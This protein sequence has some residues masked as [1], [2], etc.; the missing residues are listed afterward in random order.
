M[1][2]LSKSEMID[3]SMNSIRWAT[4]LNSD[5][6]SKSVEYSEN[7]YT[8]SLTQKRAPQKCSI[9]LRLGASPLPSRQLRVSIAFLFR[10]SVYKEHSLRTEPVM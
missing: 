4:V 9:P 10:P 1:Y 8:S 6:C 2:K 7:C 3:N 5:R